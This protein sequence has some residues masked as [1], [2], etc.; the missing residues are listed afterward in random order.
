MPLEHLPG[1]VWQRNASTSRWESWKRC[2][3]RGKTGL[4]DWFLPKQHESCLSKG[5][6]TDGFPMF[7]KENDHFFDYWYITLIL[8]SSLFWFSTCSSG[9][10]FHSLCRW[11]KII[12]ASMQWRPMAISFICWSKGQTQGCF[13]HSDLFYNK[14]TFLTSYFTVQVYA[15]NL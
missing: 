13:V 9:P 6:I 7:K 15:L 5:H 11:Y 8:M 2:S 12:A 1:V 10:T 3:G 14:N 4:P